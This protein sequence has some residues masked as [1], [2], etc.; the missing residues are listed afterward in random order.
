[1]ACVG[2][3][4]VLLFGGYDDSVRNNEA[5]LGIGF[6]VI[7]VK[8]YLPLLMKSEAALM[9][10]AS[11]RQSCMRGVLVGCCRLRRSLELQHRRGGYCRGPFVAAL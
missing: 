3:D 7:P 4:Q 6:G 5:W 11:L 9:G 8:V 1:M 2:G 10:A